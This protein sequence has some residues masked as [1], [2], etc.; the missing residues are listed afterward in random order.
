MYFSFSQHDLSLA[1]CWN[2]GENALIVT[3]E[4]DGSCG[5]DGE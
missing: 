1:N 2:S 5:V 3:C 4:H